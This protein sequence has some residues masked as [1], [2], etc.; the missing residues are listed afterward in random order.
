MPAVGYGGSARTGI[1]THAT[2]ELPGAVRVQ[3]QTLYVMRDPGITQA[4][5]ERGGIDGALGYDLFSRFTVTIDYA[6]KTLTLTDPAADAQNPSGGVTLPL[7]LETRTPNVTASVDGRK[8]GRFLIDSGDSGAVHLFQKY[9]RANGLLPAANDP[10]AQTILGIGIGGVVKETVTPGHSLTLGGLTL[11]Q[12]PLESVG[13]GGIA[14]VLNEAG[15]IGN[16]VLKKFVVT[17]DYAHSR[18]HLQKA[19]G[20]TPSLGS[21]P[22]NPSAPSAPM[23]SGR[24]QR[25]APTPTLPVGAALRGRPALWR[26]HPSYCPT[27]R[28]TLDALLQRHLAALGGRDAVQA[29][30]STRVTADVQTGG[31]TGTVVTVF[32]VPDK[33]FE[34]DKLGILDITQ[35]YDGKVAWRRD[36]NGN[37]RLLGGDEVKSLRNQLFFDT[38]SYVIPGRIAGKMTLRPQAD[39]A[40]GDYVIDA[41]PDGGKPTTLFLDPK[42]FLIAQEQHNDD[43]VTVT[44]AYSD[45][46]A[47]NGVQFPFAQHTTN[48]NTRYDITIRVRST[49]NNVPTTDAMF[50]EPAA[51]GKAAFVAPG[52]T[53][54]TVPFDFDDG[55]IALKVAINGQPGRVFLD[56]GA[57]GIALSKATADALKLPQGGFLEARGYGGSS[58]L[59]PVKVDT[60]EIPGAV[61]LSDVAAVAIPL[62][63]ALNSFLAQPI[64]GFVGYDLLSHF[65]VRIDYAR[66]QITFV[67]PDAFQPAPADGSPLPIELDNDIPTI[68]AQLDALSPARYLLDTG[69]EAFL[70]LYGPYVTQHKLDKTYPHGIPT[71]GGGIGGVSAARITRVRRFTVAGQT[72]RGVPADF[73]LD[74]KGGASRI[75]AGAIGSALLARFVVTFDYPHGRVFLAPNADTP[76]PFDTRTSGLTLGLTDG[77]KRITVLAISPDSPAQFSG[78]RVLDDIVSVDGTP[79]SQLGLGAVRRL[80]SGEGGQTSR[81][82][83]IQARLGRPR[84]VRIAL[85]DPLP[86]TASSSA[87][88]Q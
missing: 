23:K 56:S 60:F 52:A 8:P 48:G 25:A 33:E 41:L 67:A 29:I 74:T 82:L 39:P 49:E 4:L 2:L 17:F 31:L 1:A 81:L 38:N 53:S 32:A 24:P 42:T 76:R 51:G 73:S 40:T 54:A 57:S 55:E 62:P 22:V 78:V 18:L 59:L 19:P 86:D 87:K 37:T 28:M 7:R 45:Y 11:T 13:G 36:T 34:E 63:P 16:A 79:T 66:R 12:V 5:K 70:R 72:L 64:A 6:Q 84:T 44:T 35:G 47:V 26:G 20:Y 58:D 15:G 71:V 21:G 3:G 85:Y 61:R 46:R 83:V 80:L 75:D 43:N 10:N 77:Q 68:T 65:V 88:A 69:D 9:A 27:P 30:Q 14:D 50:R